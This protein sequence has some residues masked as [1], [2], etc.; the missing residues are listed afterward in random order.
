M[1][2]EGRSDVWFSNNYNCDGETVKVH[3]MT[4]RQVL[5]QYLEIQEYQ[6]RQTANG[7]DIDLLCTQTGSSALHGFPE[8]LVLLDCESWS[9]RKAPP[10]P[11]IQ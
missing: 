9:S 8:K 3:H 10:T 11:I 7:A 1:I 5:G 4:F 6:V 2:T